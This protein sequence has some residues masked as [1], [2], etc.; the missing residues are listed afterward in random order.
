M[1]FVGNSIRNLKIIITINLK[2]YFLCEG[3]PVTA[4]NMASATFLGILEV[5]QKAARE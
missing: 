2:D 5:K 1:P 4:I 3:F